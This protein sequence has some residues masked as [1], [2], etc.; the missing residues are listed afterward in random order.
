MTCL[1]L[2][3]RELQEDMDLLKATDAVLIYVC[4]VEKGIENPAVENGCGI[5]LVLLIVK[6]HDNRYATNDNITEDTQQ[7][8]YLVED[9]EAEQGGKYNL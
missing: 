3:I 7:I 1:L 6:K 5:F 9:K 2:S 4:V 8:R